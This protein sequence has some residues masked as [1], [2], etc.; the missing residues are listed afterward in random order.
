[1]GLTAAVLERLVTMQGEDLPVRGTYRLAM[2]WVGG[3]VEEVAAGTGSR[4][5]PS[6]TALFENLKPDHRRTCAVV[7]RLTAHTGAHVHAALSR[8]RPSDQLID[9]YRRRGPARGMG[10]RLSV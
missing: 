9:S 1:M 2:P 10:Y 6:C 3:D 5:G 8:K 4:S 7:D